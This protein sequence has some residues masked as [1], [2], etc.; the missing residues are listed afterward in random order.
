MLKDKNEG[1]NRPSID[2]LLKRIDSKYKLA[3]LS[4][5][6]AHVIEK[7]NSLSS[8]KL[9]SKKIVSKALSE[10]INDNFKIVFK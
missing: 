7:N 8:V 3:F 6:I 4:G 1:I 5:K 2:E 9:P 10:I